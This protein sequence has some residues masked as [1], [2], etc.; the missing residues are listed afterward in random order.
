MDVTESVRT[1]GNAEMRNR[2]QP[3]GMSV[4]ISTGSFVTT[5]LGNDEMGPTSPSS[6]CH[7]GILHARARSSRGAVSTLNG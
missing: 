6:I 5:G 7:S 4:T 3:I 1:V 2:A